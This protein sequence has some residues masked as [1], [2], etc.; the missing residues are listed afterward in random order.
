[1]GRGTWCRLGVPGAVLA[2]AFLAVPAAVQPELREALA[3]AGPADRVAIVVNLE[4]PALP[5]GTRPGVEQLRR[6]SA[7]AAGPVLARLAAAERDGLAVRPALIWSAGV[8]VARVVPALVAEL[9]R[10]PGVREVRLDAPLLVET[11][12]GDQSGPSPTA[13]PT[14]ALDKMHVE[15]VWNLGYTGKNVVVAHIDSGVDIAHPD[16]ADHLWVNPGEIPGDGIDNDGNGYRDDVHGCDFD[17]N[18]SCSNVP[19]THGTLTAGLVL[20]DGHG[21]YQTGVAPDAELMVLRHAGTESSAWLASLYAIQHGADLITQAFS[22][23]YDASPNYEAWRNQAVAELAAGIIHVNSAGNTSNSMGPPHN[24]NAPANCPPPFLH[25][26]Q[27]VPG[28]LSSVIGVANVVTPGGV[29]SGTSPLGPSEW[30]DPPLPPSYRDYPYDP[31]QGLLKPDLAAYGDGSR[32]TAP[33]GGYEFLQGTSAAASHVAGIVALLLEAQPAATPA[34]LAEALYRSVTDAGDAGWDPLYGEGIVDAKRALDELLLITCATLGGDGDGDG[35]CTDQ[36]NC[37]A[38]ANPAQSDLDGDGTGDACDDDADGDTHTVVAGDC[39]DL[40]AAVHPGAA[41]LCNL[42]DDDCDTATDENPEAGQNSC[43]DADACTIDL[44]GAGAVCLN[45]PDCAIAGHVFYYRTLD[46]NGDGTL[47]DADELSSK[48]ISGVEL[49]LFPPGEG[50]D[51]ADAVTAP[52]GSYV[53]AGLAGSFKL[54]ALPRLGQPRADSDAPGAISSLDASAIARHA[55]ELDTLSS[56]QQLAAD[57][58]FNGSVTSYDASLVAQYSVQM[59]DHFPAAALHGSD[60][61]FLRCDGGVRENCPAWPPYPPAG[62]HLFAPLAGDATADFHGVLLGD[63]TGNREEVPALLQAPPAPRPA[64]PFQP[65]TAVRARAATLY[66]AEGPV[67]LPDGRFRVAL[68]IA[69]ADGIQAVDL[70]LRGAA[71]RIESV[72]AL[73]IAAGYAAVG[74]A[75]PARHAIAVFGTRPMAG[76]GSFLEVVYSVAGRAAASLPFGIEASANE[77]LV[78]LAWGARPPR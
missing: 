71:A 8:V 47:D 65:L 6:R 29:V 72:R 51:G 24:V 15:D 49:D 3:A 57:V 31:G 5:D 75:L 55:V 70:A 67:R 52:D 40:D 27:G 45:Q 38:V 60:W 69:D 42:V 64:V 78:P 4:L 66:L 25:A 58:S 16:L 36:D 61:A 9:D 73:G 68:G 74:H 14:P 54:R 30:D 26:A 62:E 44:C 1:M 39:N 56:L 17:G 32:S 2:A 22:F 34:Q 37:D 46:A 21:G 18:S 23:R 11:G 13:T 28:G 33:G 10:V 20:G 12:D 76:T 50:P 41:E 48:A 7:D 59:F 35:V 19:D 53:I 63:V 77:G 43:A